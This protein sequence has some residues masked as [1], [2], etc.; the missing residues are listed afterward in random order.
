MQVKEIQLRNYPYKSRKGLSEKIAKKYFQKKGYEVFRA[1]MVL[2]KEFSFYYEEYENV[3]NKYDRLEKILIKKLNLKLYN[4]RKELLE[5]GG[6]PDYFI[7]RIGTYIF[8]EIKLEHE[9]IK[10]HQL[11]CMKIIESYGFQ[12]MLIRIKSKLY[13][14]NSEI[15]LNG[16]QEDLKLKNRRIIERQKKL[17]KKPKKL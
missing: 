2:G 8:T 14:I 11:Q 3:K 6:I 7:H 13:R 10:P 5:A 17:V 4:F 12:T 1:A 16:N 9:S 15:N